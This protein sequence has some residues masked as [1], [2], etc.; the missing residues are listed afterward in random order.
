[1]PKA[2]DIEALKEQF[3][4]NGL[5]VTVKF[6]DETSYSLEPDRKVSDYTA[7][8]LK[9]ITNHTVEYFI[10][11]NGSYNL[12]QHFIDLHMEFKRIRLSLVDHQII[13][14][15]EDM[16][17]TFGKDFD[18]LDRKISGNFIDT[19]K[20]A[21]ES[22]H[23]LMRAIPSE[24]LTSIKSLYSTYL[25]QINEVLSTESVLKGFKLKQGV[26]VDNLNVDWF[27][28]MLK[29]HKFIDDS[30]TAEEVRC[31][32][33]GV[34]KCPINWKKRLHT[35]S[36]LM[37]L[38]D[39]THGVIANTGKWPTACEIFTVEGEELVHGKNYSSNRL[40]TNSNTAKQLR[41]D[42]AECVAELLKNP[43][44]N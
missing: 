34:L 9:A 18:K 26:S 39:E 32:F 20:E 23:D 4:L 31:L 40:S 24:A 38:L 13:S 30:I 29:T 14:L 27:T 12:E 7:D 44:K 25:W 1:M 19:T 10:S 35:F 3:H 43:N 6:I 11:I 22:T 16:G 17:F 21:K 15:R 36:E 8:E 33:G 41:E 28:E 37:Y 42:V 5:P 2:I